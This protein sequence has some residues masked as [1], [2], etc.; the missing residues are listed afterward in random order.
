MTVI[1]CMLL[2]TN[3]PFIIPIRYG[4]DPSPLFPSESC[5]SPPLLSSLPPHRAALLHSAPSDSADRAGG[6]G[7]AGGGVANAAD[8]A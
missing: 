5:S 1:D 8:V 6:G 4:T 3:T 2:L 7:S